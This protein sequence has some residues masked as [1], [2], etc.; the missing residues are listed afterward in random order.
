MVESRIVEGQKGYS[1]AMDA[2]IRDELTD[3]IANGLIS[4]P[5]RSAS[6]SNTTVPVTV[7]RRRGTSAASVALSL[8]RRQ[9][10]QHTAPLRKLRKPRTVRFS[11]SFFSAASSSEG[12]N[13][14]DEKKGKLSAVPSEDELRA[15]MSEKSPSSVEKQQQQAA[16]AQSSLSLSLSKNRSFYHRLRLAILLILVSFAL[17][18]IVF[19]L[20]I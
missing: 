14:G 3:D 12:E 4:L 11:S 9:Q 2:A 10:H 5:T 18:L 19:R 17:S 8:R 7:P 13:A 20:C 6:H 16:W 1:S 15:N